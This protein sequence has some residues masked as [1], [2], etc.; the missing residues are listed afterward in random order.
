MTTAER[1]AKILSD[2]GQTWEDENGRTLDDLATEHGAYTERHPE[3]H[4]LT[5]Y[6][7]PDGS[8]IVASEGAW[9][10]EGAEPW[11]WRC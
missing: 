10:I 4:H 8:A 1:I 3:K 11:S 7:F 5:R 6:V 2:D 9:D